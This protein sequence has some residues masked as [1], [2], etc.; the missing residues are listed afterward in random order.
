MNYG[1]NAISR[2]LQIQVT[3]CMLYIYIY[4]V[5]VIFLISVLVLFLGGTT[6][7][8][9]SHLGP[10]AVHYCYKEARSKPACIAETWIKFYCTRFDYLNI[11]L[12]GTQNKPTHSLICIYFKSG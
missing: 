2:E 10:E 12:L 11:F 8:L 3:G 4:I 9:P 5:K 7:L 6:Q 1:S